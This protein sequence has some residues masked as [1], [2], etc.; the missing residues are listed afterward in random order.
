MRNKQK[1]SQFKRNSKLNL[2]HLVAAAGIVSFCCSLGAQSTQLQ[3]VTLTEDAATQ[4]LSSAKASLSAGQVVMMYGSDSAQFFG[5]LGV[6]LELEHQADANG[7]EQTDPGVVQLMA[8]RIGGD[9]TLHSYKCYAPVQSQSATSEPGGPCSEAFQNWIQQEQQADAN[10]S[11]PLPEDWTPLGHP[12]T[13]YVD[14]N[15]NRFFDHVRLYRANDLLLQNDHYLIIRDP[16]SIPKTIDTTRGYFTGTRDFQTTLFSTD[17]RFSIYELSPSANITSGSGKVS[18]G[19]G[20]AE[21]VPVPSGVTVE[22]PWEQPAVQTTVLTNLASKSASWVEQIDTS[23]ANPS[24]SQPFTSHNAMIFQVPE[25]TVSFE[26]RLTSSIKNVFSGATTPINEQRWVS[27]PAP[28]F[29]VSPMTLEVA[30]KG[31]ATLN[32]NASITGSSGLKWKV[33]PNVAPGLTVTPMSGTGPMVV[34]I[35]ATSAK[36]GTID[37]IQFQTDPPNGASSVAHI[38]LEVTVTVVE[39]ANL[40]PHGVLIAGGAGSFGQMLTSAEIWNPDTNTTTTTYPMNSGRRRHAATLLS[41]GM[42]ILL[43]GGFDDRE[44]SHLSLENT[45]ETFDATTKRFTTTTG[46][47][48]ARRAMHTATLITTGPLAGDVLIVGG[49]CDQNERGLKTSELYDPKSKTFKATGSLQV[50]RMDQTATVLEDGRILIVGGTDRS[51]SYNGIS[52][53]EIY[54]P[55]NGTFSFAGTLKEG[56]QGHTATLLQNGQVLIAGG[57]NGNNDPIRTAELYTVSSKSF[58]YTGSMGIGR[59]YSAAIGLQD[60]T[61][62]MAGGLN[63]ANSAQTYSPDSLTFTWTA[64][65]MAE[66]R[67]RP[68][69]AL[70][71]NTEAASDG[72]V[73]IVGG[74]TNL[75]ELYNPGT[76]SFSSAGQMS[77]RRSQFSATMFNG[78]H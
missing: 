75:L 68:A 50:G 16:L 59:R 76:R 21:D 66:H 6:G 36:E 34:T 39:P 26:A 4:D 73:F 40:P 18:I 77:V 27:L 61:V 24:N 33:L 25:S 38:P 46:T 49:C 37:Y 28:V 60:G 23:T 17:P 54:D 41:D 5:L 11:E 52:E 35:E 44:N 32:L 64:N 45:A 55:A 51:G 43:T 1:Q 70:I 78:A 74:D 67:D 69:G 65:N 8:A 13:T 9:G 14:G 19:S 15:G 58:T 42:T 56:R 72:M 31:K 20:L 12:D 3:V 22:I 71:V 47:M 53:A 10:P 7:A 57:W 2:C 62:L 48:V 30:P 29:T 63:G